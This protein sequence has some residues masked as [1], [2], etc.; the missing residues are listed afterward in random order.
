[1]KDLQ[2]T[3]AD[4]VFFCH[5]VVKTRAATGVQAMVTSE[6][7]QTHSCFL[8]LIV[9]FIIWC[10]KLETSFWFDISDGCC[11][12]CMNHIFYFKCSLI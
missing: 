6:S 11:L 3:V 2:L 12:H 9:L 5:L 4:E 7:I 10:I 8:H 1:M